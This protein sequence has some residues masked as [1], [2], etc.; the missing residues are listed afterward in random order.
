[1][2][3]FFSPLFHSPSNAL[4]SRQSSSFLILALLLFTGASEHGDH[5]C[6]HDSFDGCAGYAQ[7]RLYVIAKAGIG[8][9]KGTVIL[10]GAPFTLG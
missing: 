6:W 1:M 4:F 5:I 2:S 3:S 10:W 8:N 9:S 7:A